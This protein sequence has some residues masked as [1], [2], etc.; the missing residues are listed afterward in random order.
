MSLKF[1]DMC[2][3]RDHN[4]HPWFEVG[5][6][7]GVTSVLHLGQNLL[8]PDGRLLR[9]LPLGHASS[10]VPSANM[11]SK[12]VV[13]SLCK[14]ASTNNRNSL[15]ITRHGAVSNGSVVPHLG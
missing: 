11:F 14:E 15:S 4:L 2:K 13:N 3:D 5:T 10:Q 8:A 1:K 7:R 9:T 6:N 12:P